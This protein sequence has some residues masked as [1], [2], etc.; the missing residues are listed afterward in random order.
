MCML[1][2]R[3][4]A[5]LSSLVVIRRASRQSVLEYHHINDRNDSSYANIYIPDETPSFISPS[6]TLKHHYSTLISTLT[7]HSITSSYY[8]PC[9]S[10]PLPLPLSASATM[11]WP[12]L[13]PSGKR[14]QSRERRQSPGTMRN[15]FPEHSP[16]HT[17]SSIQQRPRQAPQHR[18]AGRHSGRRRRGRTQRERNRDLRFQPHEGTERCQHL[19]CYLRH[20]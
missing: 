15:P 5:F 10:Q 8:P 16:S 12:F 9:A 18:R 20:C 13:F 1:G 4:E 14:C 17:N 7:T 6:S 2:S 19:W 3:R 11:P